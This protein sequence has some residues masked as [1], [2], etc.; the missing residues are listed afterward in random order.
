MIP[1][2]RKASLEGFDIGQRSWQWETSGKLSEKN[3]KT[4]VGWLILY[5]KENDMESSQA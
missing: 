2:K 5:Q 4:K 3:Q 1:G